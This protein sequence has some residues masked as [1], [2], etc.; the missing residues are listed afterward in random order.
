MAGVREGLKNTLDPP[1][2]R[3]CV[4]IGKFNDVL[5]FVVFLIVSFHAS[6][7][8]MLTVLSLS[9]GEV[10]R[11]PQSFQKLLDV[12]FRGHDN[13]QRGKIETPP[14]EKEGRGGFHKPAFY[15]R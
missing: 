9:K 13:N 5:D 3:G 7:S 12:R 14:L 15:H 1:L 8:T 11:G 2:Q 10:R 6:R 4:A